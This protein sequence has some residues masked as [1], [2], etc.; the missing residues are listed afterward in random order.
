MVRK[1]HRWR[2]RFP[3]GHRGYGRWCHRCTVSRRRS[4]PQLQR[5]HRSRPR[6]AA[7][8]RAL[9]QRQAEN[10]QWQQQFLKD[11][12]PLAH[13]PKPVAIKTRLILAALEQ[14]TSP[15]ELRGKRFQFDRTLLR[16][17]VGY[18]Y[19]LLCRWQKDSITPLGVMSHEAYNAIARNKKRVNGS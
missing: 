16:I 6:I 14:G 11:P 3:C 18:R 9:A 13:L 7:R 12:I 17:P 1:S 2:K 4:L 15:T 10:Q 19:R 8:F 5:R